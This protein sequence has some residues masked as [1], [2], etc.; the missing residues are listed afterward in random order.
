LS[1]FCC[2]KDCHFSVVLMVQ[3][4]CHKKFADNISVLNFQRIPL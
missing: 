1:R 3:I 4:T 2:A